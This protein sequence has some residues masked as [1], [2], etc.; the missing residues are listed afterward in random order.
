[1]E[2]YFLQVDRLVILFI[3]ALAVVL[4]LGFCLLLLQGM[5]MV[6]SIS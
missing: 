2:V 6:G 5:V 1:M 4:E 3:L